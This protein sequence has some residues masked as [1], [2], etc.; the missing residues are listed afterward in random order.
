[1][2]NL[3][4][5]FI[6][7]VGLLLALHVPRRRALLIGIK[8]A[9][10]VKRS[11]TS[12][13]EI[14]VCTALMG[15][16]DDVDALKTLLVTRGYKPADIVT[17]KDDRDADASLQPTHA[18]IMRELDNLTADQKPGDI[19]FFSYS[20]HSYYKKL[21]AGIVPTD[22]LDTYIIPSDG[23]AC[24]NAI[25][26]Y[27]KVI[28]AQLKLV[29]SLLLGSRLIAVL[30]TCH[31]ASLLN[32]PH[33]KCNRIASWR[34][35]LR[36][37]VRWTRELFQD[38]NIAVSSHDPILPRRG[39]CI[40][41]VLSDQLKKFQRCSGYCLRPWTPIIPVLCI[42]A[43][44]DLQTVYEDSDGTSLTRTFIDVLYDYPRPSLAQLMRACSRK[45]QDVA[46]KAAK[47]AIETQDPSANCTPWHPQLSSLAPLSLLPGH[48]YPTQTLRIPQLSHCYSRSDILT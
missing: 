42:S 36:R 6:A 22:P 27:S 30:D 34:S 32:L 13:T 43:C 39:S 21:E 2:A 5:R 37:S 28:S 16:F 45:S 3:I 47:F 11:N 29:Q 10:H 38:D 23:G 18:N 48:P 46:S 31:S 15:P 40:S 7:Q 44:K 26:D 4:P 19:F 41:S 35:L 17:L 24:L 33:S 12:D 1:M 8:S 20:G 9:V 25:P 14:S